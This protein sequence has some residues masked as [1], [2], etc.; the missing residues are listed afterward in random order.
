[1]TRIVKIKIKTGSPSNQTSQDMSAKR[2]PCNCIYNIVSFYLQ[3]RITVIRSTTSLHV[4]YK[5]QVTI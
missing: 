3:R 5:L 2:C 1:M 4:N